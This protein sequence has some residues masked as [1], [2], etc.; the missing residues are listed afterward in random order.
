M[1]DAPLYDELDRVPQGGQAVWRTAADGT[2]IRTAVWHGSGD[3]TV[4]IF[5]G[6]TEFIEKYGDVI[7]R[8]L[9]RGYSVAIID[10]RGQGLSDR[11]P[12]KRD[13]GWVKEFS[14]Y[15][16]DVAELLGTVKDAGL[17]D[18]YALIAH[19]M[20]GAIGPLKKPSSAAQCG[21]STSNQKCVSQPRL[22]QVLD[23]HW[24][25]AKNSCLQAAA[26]II[27]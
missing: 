21:A 13:M 16:L 26:I 2:R 14:E 22:S 10:W 15:Q 20:G 9:D 8:L 17:P 11:H 24:G 4:L 27:R 1:A 23:P 6:R 12:N 5:P 25:L 19:S 18:P 3:K 7:A